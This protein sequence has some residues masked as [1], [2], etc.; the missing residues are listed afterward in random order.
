MNAVTLGIDIG[1][2]FLTS[3]A[4]VRLAVSCFARS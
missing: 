2:R 3:S 1:K 4:W